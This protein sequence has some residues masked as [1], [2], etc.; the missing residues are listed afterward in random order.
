MNFRFSALSVLLFA[1]FAAGC[2]T[3][4]ALAAD[5]SPV[6]ET[7]VILREKGGAEIEDPADGPEIAE[8]TTDQEHAPLEYE[9]KY[10]A[11]YYSAE[12]AAYTEIEAN[13]GYQLSQEPYPADTGKPFRFPCRTRGC[14]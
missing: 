8:E 6:E 7:E 4:V 13:Y 12:R 2:W 14:Q 11:Y 10:T 3:P 1:A 9:A 5:R